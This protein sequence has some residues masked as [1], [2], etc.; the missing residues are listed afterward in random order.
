MMSIYFL[1]AFYGQES[2][3]M[4]CNNELQ[5]RIEPEVS[6]LVGEPPLSKLPL[7]HFSVIYL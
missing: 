5:V 6:V 1:L 3:E 2:G 7:C 4:T